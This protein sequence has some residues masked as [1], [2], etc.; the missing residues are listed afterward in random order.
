MQ[1]AQLIGKLPGQGAFLTGVVKGI[2]VKGRGSPGWASGALSGSKKDITA[3]HGISS[4]A[5]QLLALVNF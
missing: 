5:I 1:L 3:A 4:L 2:S